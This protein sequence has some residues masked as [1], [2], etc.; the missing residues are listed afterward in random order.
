MTLVFKRFPT[1]YRRLESN[2]LSYATEADAMTTTP[3]RQGIA[4]RN[5]FTYAHSGNH[6]CQILYQKSHFGY[7][8]ERLRMENVGVG[9][10]LMA[11]WNVLPTAIW[12]AYFLA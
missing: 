6:G 10:C 12:K 11:T 4:H 3:R 8:L 7:I 1:L 5:P 9:T 2:P